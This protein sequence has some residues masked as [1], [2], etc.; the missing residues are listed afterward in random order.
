MRLIGLAVVRAL[1]LILAPLVVEAQQPGKVYRIGVLVVPEGFQSNVDAFGDGMRDLGYTEGKNVII[2][3][4]EA[5]GRYERLPELVSDLLRLNPEAIVTSGVPGVRAVER[6]S[7]TIPIIMT[8]VGDAVETGIVSSLARPGGNITGLSFFFPELAAKR[9]ELMNEAIPKLA[10]VGLF[11]NPDNPGHRRPQMLRPF[12]TIAQ[13]LKVVV[14][15][16]EVRG[17]QDLDDVF[18]TM[19]KRKVQAVVVLE[20]AVLNSHPDAIVDLARRNRMATIGYGPVA[21]AGGLLAYAPDHREMWRRAATFVDKILKGAKPADLPIEQ[22]T[23]FELAINMKTAKALG[24]TIP[25][26]LLLRADHII[27]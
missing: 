13:S 22:P 19:A 25:Q 6:L 4:R 1:S 5:G 20:D 14:E 23:K 7:K 26:T 18:I 11:M 27:E 9:L 16:A 21:M 15:R 12:W 2:E 8:T 24:L 17:R 10:R 3:Y